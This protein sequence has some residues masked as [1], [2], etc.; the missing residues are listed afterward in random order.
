MV[1]I[2]APASPSNGTNLGTT[3][4]PAPSKQTPPPALPPSNGGNN[5]N[6]DDDDRLKGPKDW[7]DIFYTVP[8]L[9]HEPALVSLVLVV[10]YC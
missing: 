8:R 4:P 10:L 7:S 5:Q 2:Q 1:A 3:P 9:L 6:C